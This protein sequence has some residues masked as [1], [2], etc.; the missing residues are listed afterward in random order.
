MNILDTIKQYKIKE[1]ARQKAICPIKLLEQS[2]FFESP[3]VSFSGYVVDPGRSG[4]IAEFKRKSPS[5]GDI[6]KYA[7]PEEVTVGY[8]QAGAAALSVLTDEH[9]F[10]AKKEDLPTARRFNFCPILRKEFIVDEYQIIEAKSLGA[11]AIL[12]IAKM[13]SVKEIENFTTLAQ[14]LG[15]EVLLETH[16]EAEVLSH[17]ESKANAFGINNRN[18]ST[19]E[20]SVENSIRLSEMLPKTKLKIAESGIDS[21]ETIKQLKAN[22]FDGFLIGEYFMKHSNPGE[23]CKELIKN[24]SLI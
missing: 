23:K 2:I 4:I 9:F 7:N 18:L 12:L 15:M 3:C 10:G 6:N 16:T 13:I 1:V 20:V 8:M 17:S 5:K 21:L 24:L 11:D 22:G 14:Q 19:F